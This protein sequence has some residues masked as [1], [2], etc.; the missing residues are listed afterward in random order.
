MK[1]ISVKLPEPMANWL[2]RRAKETK[3][4]RSSVVREAL[5]RERSG[6]ERPK[7]CHDLLQ[8]V[9]GSFDGPPDLSTNPKYMEGFGR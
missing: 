5:E 8:D 4:T 3:R 9:C 6:K 1:T 7:S 2:A